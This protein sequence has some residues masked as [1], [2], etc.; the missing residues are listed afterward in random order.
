[1]EKACGDFSGKA[2]LFLFPTKPSWGEN[3]H[4]GS[5]ERR[6]RRLQNAPKAAFLTGCVSLPVGGGKSLTET[7]A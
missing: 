2:H 6:E 3:G 5:R 1:M 7:K 4:L